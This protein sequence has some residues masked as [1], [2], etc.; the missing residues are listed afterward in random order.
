MENNQF[1]NILVRNCKFSQYEIPAA[2]DEDVRTIR[3]FQDDRITT[4]QEVY[5]TCMSQL[6]RDF[7]RTPNS[8]ATDLCGPRRIFLRLYYKNIIS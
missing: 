1:D 3:T 4:D 7:N 6:Q 2:T 5:N 8:I